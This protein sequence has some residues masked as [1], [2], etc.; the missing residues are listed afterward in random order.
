GDQ[1]WFIRRDVKT[2]AAERS[3]GRVLD[4]DRPELPG[5]LADAKGDFGS[6]GSPLVNTRGE[7][8]GVVYSGQGDGERTDSLAV[9]LSEITSVLSKVDGTVTSLAAWWR[10][11]D[12][13]GL[14]HARREQQRAYWYVSRGD[15]VR[16]IEHARR[17]LV[18]DPEYWQSHELL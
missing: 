15:R 4:V 7:V 9:P 2:E 13:P 10:P 17:A 18:I 14:K 11:Q 1:V 8:V 6:S 12:R 16:A 3:G 5:L